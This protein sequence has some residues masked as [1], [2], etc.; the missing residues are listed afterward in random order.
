MTTR[1]GVT[2]YSD[3]S[4]IANVSFNAG[5]TLLAG[6]T[7]YTASGS[8][9]APTITSN[10]GGAT[11]SVSVAVPSQ[12][13]TTV[14]ATGT[15][16]IS[17]YIQGGADAALFRI[18]TSSGVLTF[19]AAPSVGTY[20]VVVGASNVRGAKAQTITV[21]G[22]SYT[23]PGD[24]VAFTAWYG[25]RA[26]SAAKCGTACCRVVRASDSTQID[27]NS[28]ADGSLDAATLATFLAATTGKFV[29]WYDQV[30]SNDLT[31]GTDGNRPA[32]TAN[33]VNTS[34][35]ATFDGGSGTVL[36][37]GSNF[38]LTQP[39]SF[40]A[41]AKQPTPAGCGLLGIDDGSYAGVV[42]EFTAGPEIR[43]YAG[44]NFNANITGGALYA[45]EF[46]VNGASSVISANGTKTTGD[47]GAQDT[48]A[49]PFMIGNESV[50]GLGVN[51]LIF[52][53][54]V[55][56]NVMSVINQAAINTNMRAAYGGF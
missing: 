48:G 31:Q 39:Y 11:A 52:E 2:L 46:V 51:G 27:I 16:P 47:A 32:V 15:A 3:V 35:G 54:G 50:G 4:P 44:S 25:L 17:F 8:F 41:T 37:T 20:H 24:I 43:I 38:N 7:G 29:T 6:S 40:V 33:A 18:G 19:K 21:T 55:I 49:H 45:F 12:T 22:A 5:V 34:Y 28:A 42:V 13:V 36:V 30:G 14:T 56:N 53:A 1:S 23:G 26:Y 9:T 10:G